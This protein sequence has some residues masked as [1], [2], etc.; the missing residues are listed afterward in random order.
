MQRLTQLKHA[1]FPEK[2]RLETK[3][4]LEPTVLL[5]RLLKILKVYSDSK[6]IYNL[7]RGPIYCLRVSRDLF[8]TL[9]TNEYDCC[10]GIS[11][12]L[13]IPYRNLRGSFDQPEK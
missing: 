10:C 7:F 13:F 12:I 9:K 3:Q 1:Y 11:K 8:Q 2:S 5:N 4:R 6:Q